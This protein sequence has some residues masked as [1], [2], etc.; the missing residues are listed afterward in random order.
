MNKYRVVGFPVAHSLSPSIHTA[1]AKQVGHDLL[2]DKAEVV[3]GNLYH[4]MKRFFNEEGGHGMNVTVPLKQEVIDKIDCPSD[5]VIAT[6]SLNTI[7]LDAKGRTC[8]DTTDGRGLVRDLLSNHNIEIQNKRVLL[9]GSGGAVA[10]ILADCIAQRPAQ[11]FLVGRNITRVA[12]LARRMQDIFPIG[13]CQ[14]DQLLKQQQF[15]IVINGTITSMQNTVPPLP[16]SVLAQEVCCY[17]MFYQ[18]EETAFQCWARQNGVKYA[19]DGLG[20]LV[21]QAAVS[22]SI[23]RNIMPPDTKAVIQS[24]RQKLTT[25]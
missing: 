13:Y 14:Y 5:K 15:D 21:E 11:I 18:K 2:Y 16:T 25:N 17:D 8:A 1:F 22:F 3:P 9:L 12:N 20:M 6:G 10:G 7:W 4:A 24:L 23:W 19:L